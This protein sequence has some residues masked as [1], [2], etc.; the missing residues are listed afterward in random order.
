[1]VRIIGIDPGL[2]NTGWGVIEQEGSRLTYIADG[3]VH[4]AAD[5]GLS[6]RLSQIHTQL[7]VVLREY[8]PEEAAIEETFVNKDARATLKLGQARG[9]VMLAPVKLG[10]PIAE[11]APNV[12]KKTVVGA[13]HAEKDQV[14]RMVKLLLPKALMKSADSIDALAI[15]ICHAHHRG[16]RS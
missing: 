6:Q 12:I 7:M 11:Y 13:G 10:I 5:A 4:S 15:A 16:R 14:K 2:R 8:A 1:M 3:S 9:V